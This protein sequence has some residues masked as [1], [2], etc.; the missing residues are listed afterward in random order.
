MKISL[1]FGLFSND[2]YNEIIGNSKG[3][4]QYA[5]DAL[6]KSYLEGLCGLFDDINVINLPYIGSFPSRYKALKSPSGSFS[7]IS[8]NEKLIKGKNVSFL[9]LTGIKMCSRYIAAKR[10][11]SNW[12][13]DFVD[14]E[15][16]V[17]VYA[18]HSP[19][20]KACVDV[21]KKNNNIKIVLIV[22]DLP[23]YMDD[24]SS[25]IYRIGKKYNS[26][27]LKSLYPYID[28]FVL[29]S[30]YMTEMLPIKNK[31]W[32][33]V[34]GI[35]N[36]SHDDILVNEKKGNDDIQYIFYAGTLAKRYGVMNLIYAFM[37][38]P[39]QNVRLVICGTGDSERE[40]IKCANSD[41]RIIP[42]GQL[43]RNEVLRLQKE[44]TLLVNPRTSEGEYTK[45]SFPSKTMEYL[46][47][48]IPT[49]LYGLPGIPDEYYQYCYCIEKLG[50]EALK[51][52]MIEIL[53]LPPSELKLKG[54]KA[55]DFILKK[56][57]PISQVC[58]IMNLINSLH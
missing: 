21:K 43:P 40:I 16:V 39:N 14:E 8:K 12:C 1:L 55:R 20:L 57:N 5:A 7:Y 9:N 29:L 41:K 26:I 3:N 50:I 52:K 51:D 22:P 4:I 48:G 17:L 2:K 33:V 44:S 46:A 23:E 24:N 42:M 11:L 18:I 32:V 6:Q 15:K 47:S 38:I 37:Q 34:E 27:L 56:K 31:P 36:D 53:S 13:R 25:L 35:F 54:D 45:Y 58:K 49:L 10:E 30:K 28:G 19:F